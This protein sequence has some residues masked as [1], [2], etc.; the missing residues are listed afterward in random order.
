MVLLAALYGV[1]AV[2]LASWRMA[3]EPESSASVRLAAAM[4]GASLLA[5]WTASSFSNLWIEPRLWI[6]PGL[7]LAAAIGMAI[8]RP[9]LRS[10]KVHALAAGLGL[11]GTLA[12][13]VAGLVL[14]RPADFEVRPRGGG[15]IEL[16]LAGTA[17]EAGAIHVWPDWRVGG[18]RTGQ[19]L[20]RWA[21]Q[22]KLSHPV[23][24]HYPFHSSDS[25]L[26]GPTDTV[27]LFGR[28]CERLAS[29]A[30]RG[31]ERIILLHPA[32]APSPL[33]DSARVKN[34]EVILPGI[35]QFGT[36]PGWTAWALQNAAEV[37]TYPGIGAYM[38]RAWTDELNLALSPRQVA[39]GE[40]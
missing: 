22:A 1:I 7:M 12:G 14:G 23:I 37:R 33:A 40:Q 15:V 17:G 27:L 20:K 38:A 9:W 39:G 3:R 16:R 8:K 2:Q 36:N 25:A 30:T 24:V 28:Q 29:L 19:P 11:G 4:L 32:G 21:R 5:W 26:P 18:P 13:I 35:D 6:L 34:L 31:C 10:W